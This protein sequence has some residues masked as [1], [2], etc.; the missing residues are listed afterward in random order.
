M[1]TCKR[2][3][4][5]NPPPPPFTKGGQEGLFPR[6]SV[7][8]RGFIICLLAFAAISCNGGKGAGPSPNV[9]GYP[10]TP[11][12]IKDES[13]LIGGPVAQGRVGDVLLQNDKIRVIIQKPAKNAGLFSFGGIIIDADRVRSPG[14]AGHDE[15]GSIFPLVNIEWTINYSNYEV[16]GTGEDGGP[17]ILRAYGKIDVYDYLDL[18]FVSEVAQG[19]AGQPITFSR[20]FD[21]RGDPFT[22]YDNLKGI[23]PDVVTEYRLDPGTNYVRM[24]TTFKNQGDTDAL[25]PVG[26]IING[27]GEL[28]LLIPGLGFSPDLMTQAAGDTPALIYS[29]FDGVDVS[30]GYFYD[31]TQFQDKDGNRIPSGSLTYSGVTFVVLGETI[32]KILPL[33]TGGI[34]EIR[35]S[36]PANSE[37][38]ITRYFVVGDGSS[39]SVLDGGM[40]ALGIQARP[41]SGIVST[42][43]GNPASNAIVAVQKKNGGTVVTYKTNSAGRFEGN[44]PAGDDPFSVAVG[45]RQYHI[46]VEKAG[47]H[48]NG[49]NRAG[50]CDPQ[51]IDVSSSAKIEVKCTLGEVGFIKL[52]GPVTDASTG[53]PIAARMTIAGEDP[54]PEG[55]KSGMFGDIN[56]FKHP[57]G[58]VLNQYISA[59]GTIGL[60]GQSSFPL[61]PG[62]YHF[63]FSHGTEYGAVEKD[64]VVEANKTAV[65]ETIAIPRV[66]STPGYISADFHLHNVVSPDS[67]ILPEMRVLA[68]A[69]EG[70]DVLQSSDHDY[71]FDY[72]PVVDAMTKRGLIPAGAFAG[73]MVGVEIT[74]N[75]YGHI[76]GFPMTADASSPAGGAIDWSATPLDEVSFAPDYCMS[77]KEIAE[78][79]RATP[80]E[81]VVQLNHISDSPTG[82]PVAAGWVTSRFYLESGAPP[83][84]NYADPVERRLLP[85]TG[86]PLFPLP[87][88]TSS[89]VTTDATSAEVVI[90]FDLHDGQTKFLEST[91]PTWF[92]LLNLGMI[93]TAS[94]S[95]DS[96]D[97]L[98]NPMGLPRNFIASSADPSDGQSGGLDRDAY[99]RSIN[100][101]HVIV[102][103][104]PFVTVEATGQDGSAYNVGDTLTGAEVKLAI[105]AF[106]PS[107]AWFDTIEVYANTEPI[108]IDDNL[109]NAMTGVAADP[110]EFYKP[111]HVPKY[112]Y[113]PLLAYRLADKSLANWKEENGVITAQIDT[114]IKVGEDT[115]IVVLVR[116]TKDTPGY[117]SLFPIV[118]NALKDASKKPKNFDPLNLAAF[119]ASPEVGAFA[120][121]LANPIFIDADG[122]GKFTAKYVREGTSPITQ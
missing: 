85:H 121:A 32:L 94:G 107:W 44:L 109:G 45:N 55:E 105:Q 115:W 51:D 89:L 4:Y 29:G 22:V 54:S 7:F 16:T 106:A 110:A 23:S 103:A 67:S 17:K 18:D 77:P 56:A 101:H 99:A 114:T 38:T 66:V 35:F 33:G 65:I 84:S 73:S 95:S 36:V 47:F 82:L 97:E 62:S 13:Q 60:T 74:P 8:I 96:H 3:L 57:F 72:A 79:V 90:G 49:T 31:L 41:I 15:F 25:M 81:H 26:D 87:Y 88:G 53:Q 14:E 9:S 24:D 63:V 52:S 40:T 118:T 86:D 100:E 64:V 102:S 78:A 68:A 43:D 19:I 69:A 122:D 12:T 61:E 92:N 21:D 111:Y 50:T 46:V 116:G 83:L 113:K 11:F 37:K 42:S 120:F 30:Y 76:Q 75:H 1:N 98:F 20:R 6:L 39:Q 2:R 117:R 28:N 119:H 91:L 34:P 5:S 70:M 71:H 27:S 108:P 104:G 48:E 93:L 58:I 10:D 80:G 112:G 59:K